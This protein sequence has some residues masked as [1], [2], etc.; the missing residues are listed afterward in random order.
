MSNVFKPIIKDLTKACLLCRVQRLARTTATQC[1]S[2][3]SPSTTPT[4]TR[5]A[6]ASNWHLYTT[7]TCPSWDKKGMYH[8]LNHI[9]VERGGVIFTRPFLQKGSSLRRGRVYKRKF[10]LS[11]CGS[12]DL[13]VRNHFFLLRIFNDLMVKTLQTIYFLKAQHAGN[14]YRP[15]LTQYHQVPTSTALHWPSIQWFHGLDHV[16]QIFSESISHWQPAAPCFDQLSPST[17]Q[18]HPILTQYH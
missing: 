6:R 3:S 4:T 9:R 14:Q 16:N 12:V 15:V 2:T 1:S 11:V 7:S 10:C 18:Y 5:A 17:D 8:C 13:F